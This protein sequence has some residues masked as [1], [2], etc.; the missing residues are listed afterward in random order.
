MARNI[1][2]VDDDDDVLSTVRKTLENAGLTV[3]TV[4]SGRACIDK[5]KEG[6]QGLILLDISMPEMDGWDTIREIVE[7]DLYKDIIICMCTGQDNPSEKMNPFKEYVLDY[8]RKPF[9]YTNI[10][11]TN[12]IEKIREYLSYLD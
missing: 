4:S 2:V 3:E 6:F 1:L 9:N 8:L 5:I 7:K 12:F 10:D 11:D